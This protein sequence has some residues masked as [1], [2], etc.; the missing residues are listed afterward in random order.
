MSKKPDLTTDL[1]S[2]LLGLWDYEPFLLLIREIDIF[3]EEA[4]AKL[5]G[6]DVSTS[7]WALK[8][9]E[10]RGVINGLNV[11]DMIRS[12]CRQRINRDRK[13]K[14]HGGGHEQE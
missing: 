9:A 12:S 4:V 7:A 10:L 3:K 8:T 11:V 14:L 2:D 5:L 1:A 13:N 6:M